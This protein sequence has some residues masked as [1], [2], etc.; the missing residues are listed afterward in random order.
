[1]YYSTPL[2]A[3]I[4]SIAIAG[5]LAA[6]SFS[7]E[8]F[9]GVR[10]EDSLAFGGIDYATDQGSW[11]GI[12]GLYHSTSNLAFGLEYNQSEATYADSEDDGLNSIA[13]MAIAR[14]SMPILTNMNGYGTIGLG[15]IEVGYDGGTSFPEDTGK[16]W[17]TGGQLTLGTSYAFTSS[18]NGF[19]E[20]TYQNA[21]DDV[22]IAGSDGIEY[23]ST[24]VA[25]G[26]GY[27][28]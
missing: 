14:Y 4:L 19:V 16:E 8:A 18:A 21:F 12:R 24:N 10:T 11:Y 15:Q 6:Q 13:G 1:M 7:I 17:T 23:K 20:I 25:F 5:P 22:T 27:T 3:A 26:V 28:F 2:T 9:G